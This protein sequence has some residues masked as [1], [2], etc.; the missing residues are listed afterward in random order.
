MSAGINLGDAAMHLLDRTFADSNPDIERAVGRIE[1]LTGT[2]AEL[3]EA[4]AY[5][6]L[7]VTAY[8]RIANEDAALAIQNIESVVREY[9]ARQPEVAS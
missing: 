6:A 7:Q 9:R 5:L 3:K 2:K 4:I 1:H 8:R